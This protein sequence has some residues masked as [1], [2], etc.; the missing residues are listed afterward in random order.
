MINRPSSW[1]KH[2]ARGDAHAHAG[3]SLIEVMIVLVILGLIGIAVPMLRPGASQSLDAIS[4]EINRTFSLVSTRANTTGGT[5]YLHISPTGGEHGTGR[6]GWAES[7]NLSGGTIPPENWRS[8]P[9]E[10]ALGISPEILSGPLGDTP[11]TLTDDFVFSCTGG[12]VCDLGE[13]LVARTLYLTH[14]RDPGAAAAVTFTH[15]GTSRSYR[16]EGDTWR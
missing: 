5:V 16:L 14:A 9:A 2:P 13:G 4:S 6:F 12:G 7:E 11:S 8:I 1:S 15:F 10:I 3:F